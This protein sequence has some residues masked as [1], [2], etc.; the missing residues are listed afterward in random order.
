MD[1]LRYQVDLL[2]ALNQK[3]NSDERM[4]KLILDTSHRAFLYINY[5]TNTVTTIGRWDSFFDFNISEA[6]EL[7]RVIDSFKEEDQGELRRLL[8]I[9]KEGKKEQKLD[10]MLKDE[11]TWTSVSVSVQ[12]D[13]EGNLTDKVI[14]FGDITKEKTHQEELTYMAYYDFLTGLY[15]RNYFI[16]KLKE[17]V[18]HAQRDN[19]VV[20]VMLFDID[21][22]HKI[23]D[24]RGIVTGD[25]IIQNLGIFIHELTEPNIIASRFDSDI[26]CIAIYD[27]CGHRSV[28]TVY[29][30]VKEFL[31][32]P[33][34]LTDMTD[35]SV[36]VSVG[37]AEFP[38]ASENALSLINC[39]E[40][41]MLKAKDEG[42]DNIKFF[43][44]GILNN[45]LRDVDIENKLKEAV[46][47][48]HF[49]MNYQPQFFTNSRKLRGVEALIRWK[50][51][52][53][54][55][56]SPSVFIPLAEKNGTIIPIG[57]FVLDECIR[58]FVE[59]EKKFGYDMILS[60]NISSIQ[61]SRNDFVPKVISTVSKYG[62]NPEKLE[63]EITES[64]LIND[65]K[66]VTSKMH[67]L[68]DF[69]I[70]VSLDDFGTGFSSLSYLRGLPINTL[71]IDKS[72]I[73]NVTIDDSAR[74][75]T[76]AIVS[77]AKK[78]GYET[79]AEGVESKEQLDYLS[80]ISCDLIQGYLLGKPVSKEEIEELL[81]RII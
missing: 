35:V 80:L 47:S 53:G 7:S 73:D 28:D 40:I 12:F 3:L 78:L 5:V 42:K 34:K 57:D 2:T 48:S 55:M 44:S 65:F 75:I 31:S 27:P 43:D 29:R 9:E 81:L 50:D 51:K 23:S 67:E 79:V 10:L 15:N 64:V 18:E 36:S 20:S 61:Y 16:T 59:W 68:R 70:R 1:D 62:M 41:V 32:H 25:E 6:T 13:D 24:S 30:S 69:G 11:H 77:M 8:F 22:F 58:T 14:A 33:I 45:F 56:I 21:D 19:A 39:A 37:V 26:F 63:L 52:D 17:Y 74:I 46:F 66:L 38:E 60:I 72:F 54:V 4:F 49:F 76:E 71:K